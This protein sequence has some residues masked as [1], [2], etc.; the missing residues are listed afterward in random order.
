M[1]PSKSKTT[2][3]QETYLK[4]TAIYLIIA[5]AIISISLLYYFESKIA[6]NPNN[7]TLPDKETK[8]SPNTATRIID[9]DTFELASGE[10]VR[11]LCVDTPEK[12]KAGSE[13]ATDFLFSLIYNK[14]VV[15]EKDQT[16]K[17]AYGRILRYVY[18]NDVFVN[19]QIV[20]YG[21]GD[22]FPYGNDT[23]RCNEISGIE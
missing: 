10:T 9:G 19:K 14:E 7:D 13:E 22:V 23:T 8:I 3:T 12:G 2:K 20:Q 4:Q 5:L 6:S 11:L 17:D 15:L 18:V 1:K 16:D 21:F